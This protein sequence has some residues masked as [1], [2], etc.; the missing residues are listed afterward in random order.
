MSFKLKKELKAIT[1]FNYVGSISF[2]STPKTPKTKK[3]SFGDLFI[4]LN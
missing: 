1:P 3:V 2:E 4:F